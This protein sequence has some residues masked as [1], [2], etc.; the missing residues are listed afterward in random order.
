MT[1]P[2]F[3][4]PTLVERSLAHSRVLSEGSRPG[5]RIRLRPSRAVCCAASWQVSAI[6]RARHSHV[7]MPAPGHAL[8]EHVG[9]TGLLAVIMVAGVFPALNILCATYAS[10]EPAARPA[11]RP[12]PGKAAVVC[13][14]GPF[15]AAT[16]LA[17]AGSAR[18]HGNGRARP[19]EPGS[20]LEPAEIVTTAAHSSALVKMADGSEF[21]I[22]PES[23]VSF[24]GRQGG[25]LSQLGQWLKRISTEIQHLVGPKPSNRILRPTAAIAVRAA[26][27]AASLIRCPTMNDSSAFG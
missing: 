16:V 18:A 7:K 10:A 6:R 17:I 8:K 21:N 22:Y 25:W 9:T 23:R 26:I 14:P 19:L 27:F 4:C 15:P 5:R 3:V 12:P 2:R 13:C 11:G 24:A 1:A 20:K